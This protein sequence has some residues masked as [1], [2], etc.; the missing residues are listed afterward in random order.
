MF[1][2]DFTWEY[3]TFKHTYRYD[4]DDHRNVLVKKVKTIQK[5]NAK[6]CKKTPV[7][8]LIS[9]T[10][11]IQYV[12]QFFP[13]TRQGNMRLLAHKFNIIHSVHCDVIKYI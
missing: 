2:I 9:Y 6:R 10:M 8:C 3:S 7:T 11:Q 1:K 5:L 13:C 12:F 4:L